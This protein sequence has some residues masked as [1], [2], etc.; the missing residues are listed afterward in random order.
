MRVGFLEFRLKVLVLSLLWLFGRF[1]HDLLVVF[2]GFYAS[3]CSVFSSLFCCFCRSVWLESCAIFCPET[4]TGCWLIIVTVCVKVSQVFVID[5]LV[6]LPRFWP[7]VLVVCCP[8]FAGFICVV[9][10]AT[11]HGYVV[12][13]HE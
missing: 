1:E 5:L 9:L 11:H 7:A 4:S 13:C 2:V 10:F 3:F 8:I 12:P 6:V